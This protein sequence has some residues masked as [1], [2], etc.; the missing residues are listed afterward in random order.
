MHGLLCDLPV[1]L[2]FVISFESRIFFNFLFPRQK[3]VKRK[4]CDGYNFLLYN[5]SEILPDPSPTFS[6]HRP[7]H[8]KLKVLILGICALLDH[9]FFLHFF[10]PLSPFWIH[11]PQN[12]VIKNVSLDLRLFFFVFLGV[13]FALFLL[14]CNAM[15][16]FF[17]S[18]LFPTILVSNLTDHSK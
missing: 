11:L 3:L 4:H 17:V 2:L 15:S 8:D 10:Q 18:E 5:L 9:Y 16:F 12:K 14:K 13:K 7:C 1:F 6:I